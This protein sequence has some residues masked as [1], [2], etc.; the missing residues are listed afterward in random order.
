MT[1]MTAAIEASST[2]IVDELK[3][4]VRLTRRGDV[5]V[6]RIRVGTDQI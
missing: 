5:E 1:T 2:T 3:V 4:R 6:A